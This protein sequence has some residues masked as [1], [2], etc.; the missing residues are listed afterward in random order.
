MSASSLCILNF[1]GIGTPHEG[2][3][4]DEAPYWVT[5][6]RFRAILDLAKGHEA[7][8]GRVMITFDDGNRSDLD[9][10]SPDLRARGMTGSFFV[11]TGRLDDPR[12]LSSEDINALQAD[13]MTVGLHGR[14]HVNWRSLDDAGLAT[15]TIEARARLSEIAGRP[16]DTVGIPFGAYNRR[17]IGHLKRAGFRE[18]YT[19]DGGH[20]SDARR[21]RHRTSIRSDMTDGTINAILSGRDNPALKLK[22]GLKAWLKEYVVG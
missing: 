17:V 16:I 6:D 1:H 12:Y 4:G 2:V 22:R 15:E 3:D 13:G 21:L 10:A 8:G 5:R 18:I 9:L 20:T 11:L 14:D 7:E 19:A